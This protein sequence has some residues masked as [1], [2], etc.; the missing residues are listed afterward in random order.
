L[1]TFEACFIFWGSW[2]S[3]ENWLKLKIEPPLSNLT[4]LQRWNTLWNL[5][6]FTEKLVMVSGYGYGWKSY[7]AK[8]YSQEGWRPLKGLWSHW[9]KAGYFYFRTLNCGMLVSFTL[10][11]ICFV[12]SY[13]MFT[14]KRTAVIT[15]ISYF[16]LN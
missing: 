14:E 8:L 10:C 7:L 9:T 16:L 4:C 15:L 3:S 11:F 5:S 6:P 1:T 13:K 2:G 12:F